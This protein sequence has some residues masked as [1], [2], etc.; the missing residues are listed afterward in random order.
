MSC[1]FVALQASQGFA[2][3]KSSVAASINQTIKERDGQHD[4]DFNFGTWKTQISRLKSPL[5]GSDVWV[6]WNGSVVV[7]KVWDGL[8]NL[9][10]LKIDGPAGGHIEGLTLRLY[11]PE[12][13]QWSLNWSNSSDGILDKPLI[14]EF[15]DGRGVF[16]NQEQFNGRAILVRHTYSNI[17]QDSHHFEQAFSLDGGATWETNW[18]ANLTLIKL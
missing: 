1:L 16:I 15:K 13:H 18:I 9:E 2:Q 3:S 12:W 8:A 14:G 11:N 10:E 4:F 17:T 7:R 6:E 5:T